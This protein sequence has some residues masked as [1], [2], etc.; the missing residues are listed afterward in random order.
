MEG[1]EART[2]RTTFTA[3]ARFYAQ[4]YDIGAKGF[5][6]EG[7]EDYGAK[8]EVCRNAFGEPVEEFEIQ[9]ID[10]SDLDAALFE[11]LAVSQ[12]TVLPFIDRL[13]EWDEHDKKRL[14]V[15]VDECGECFDI[16]TDDP[17]AFDIDLYEDMTL[18][19]LAYL[20]VDE[21]VFGDI[22]ERLGY[23]LDYDAIARDLAHDYT[24]T[25]I[26]GEPIVY[27]MG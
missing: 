22:P 27:R 24:E 7:R 25:V 15:A 9:F 26:A 8:A 23:Y 14:I 4:P 21:G 19:D 10:G 1:H 2:T 11:A 13:D 3:D 18:K 16:A 5:F 20:F 6:F 12:A 17:A